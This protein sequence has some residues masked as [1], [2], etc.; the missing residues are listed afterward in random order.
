MIDIHKARSFSCKLGHCNVMQDIDSETLCEYI[1][2]SV[3]TL[4]PQHDAKFVIAKTPTT[5]GEK[6]PYISL[7]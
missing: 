4:L 3:Q 2:P 5:Y 1:R 6:S 7:R